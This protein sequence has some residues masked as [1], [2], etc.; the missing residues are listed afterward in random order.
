MGTVRSD[1][2]E[3]SGVESGIGGEGE[4]A[5]TSA[6]PGKQDLS[7]VLASIR[8]L[9]TAETAARVKKRNDLQS[10]EGVL[11]L[12]SEMRVDEGATRLTSGEILSE[13]LNDDTL[14]SGAPILDEE[15]LRSVIN[16]L[17]RE[18][19]QGELGDRISRNLRKLIRREIGEVMAEQ[20]TR[21]DA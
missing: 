14:T 16:A 19:L 7:E 11:I 17:I 18:E 8:Q 10:A 5:D 1:Q 4:A 3:D 12:T 15:A 21:E 20:R 9:V 2:D 13:G 6:P